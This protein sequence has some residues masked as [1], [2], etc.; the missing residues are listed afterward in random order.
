MLC[1][2]PRISSRLEDIK[3]IIEH[4]P[5]AEQI[6]DVFRDSV[7]RMQSLLDEVDKLINGNPIRSINEDRYGKLPDKFP[8]TSVEI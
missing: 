3:R 4:M 1:I 5:K 7:A 8:P 6:D 2:D